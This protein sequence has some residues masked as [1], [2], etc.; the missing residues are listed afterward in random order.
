MMAATR[1]SFKFYYDI[2]C[3]FAYMSSTLV[4][5][6]A[7]KCGATVNWTP[8]LLGK[9]SLCNT[10]WL[11]TVNTGGLYEATQA[12]QGKDGSAYDVMSAAKLKISGQGW[13][14]VPLEFVVYRACM[15]P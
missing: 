9:N 8:V 14:L 7:Q 6:M 11:S 5:G 4:E 1:A 12:A 2:V 10:E 13:L 15:S 3:P